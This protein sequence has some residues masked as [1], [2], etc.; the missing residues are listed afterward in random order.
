VRPNV[1]PA[2]DPLALIAGIYP[3]LRLFSIGAWNLG[4]LYAAML[5]GAGLA[6]WAAH[7]AGRCEPQD[8]AGWITIVAGGTAIAGAGMGSSAGVALVGLVLLALL[9]QRIGLA[10]MALPGWTLWLL[11]GAFPLTLPF[12]SAW[13]AVAAAVAGGL[14]ALALLLWASSLLSLSA[15]LRHLPGTG[16][17]TWRS[18]VASTLSLGGGIAS[19]LLLTWLIAPVVAQLQRG[20]TPFGDLRIWP[21]AGLLALDSTGQPVATLPSLALLLLMLAV[22]AIAWIGL[23]LLSSAHD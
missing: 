6:L 11:A 21:W 23:R 19:P 7:T 10:Q 2:A 15:V 20:L 13:A 12:V 22:S 5:S 14:S 16:G 3:L 8:L 4:W 9:P 1:P 18:G 17:L